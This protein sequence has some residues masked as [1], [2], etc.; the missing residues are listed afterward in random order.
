[1]PN[2]V[3]MSA[4]LHVFYIRKEQSKFALWYLVVASLNKWSFS[5]RL[6]EFVDK[7]QSNE[8]QKEFT[9]CIQGGQ[10][11]LVKEALKSAEEP[12]LPRCCHQRSFKNCR[13]DWEREAL[14]GIHWCRDFHIFWYRGLQREIWQLDR[15]RQVKEL[16]CNFARSVLISKWVD[17]EQG[18]A[19]TRPPPPPFCYVRIYTLNT[20]FL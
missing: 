1:M 13:F 19:L 15:R 20:A 14:S 3:L 16:K 10:K 2:A 18:V 17:Y 11:R 4:N 9:A 6:L 5:S 7:Y 12:R 8:Q